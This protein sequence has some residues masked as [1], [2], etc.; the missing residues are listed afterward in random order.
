MSIRICGEV[1]ES[2]LLTYATDDNAGD[3]ICATVVARR[4]QLTKT[5]IVRL[6]V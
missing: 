6:P 4:S 3:I 2:G 1:G 5:R